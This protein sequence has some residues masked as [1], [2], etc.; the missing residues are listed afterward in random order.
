M[1]LNKNYRLATIDSP[2]QNIENSSLEFHLQTENLDLWFSTELYYL[3][4]FTIRRRIKL[5]FIM[6]CLN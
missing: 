1:A 3:C 6:K 5:P 4:I 2:E